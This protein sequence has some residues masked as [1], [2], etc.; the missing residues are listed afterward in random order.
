VNILFLAYAGFDTNS[1]LHIHG[2]ANTLS[3]HGHACAVATP[4]PSSLPDFH[5]PPL[6]Q[7]LT[8]ADLAGPGPAFPNGHPP[9]IVHAWTPRPL[10]LHAARTCLRTHPGARLFVH[11]EDDE[12]LV[13][14]RST[15]LPSALFHH[16]PDTLLRWIVPR[17]FSLPAEARRFLASASGLTL[18][19]RDLAATCPPGVPT[20]EILP[21]L[22]WEEFDPS[23]PIAPVRDEFSIPVG[24]LLLVYNGGLHRS[25][26]Q[27]QRELYR[28]VRIL[29]QTGQP[30]TLIRTGFRS[31]NSARRLGVDAGPHIIELGAVNRARMLG[32]LRAADILVQPGAPDLFNQRRLP[33]KLPEFLA[34]GKPVVLPGANL[35][36]LL[37]HG[38]DAWILRTGRAE[39]IADALRTLAA[40]PALRQDLG[41]A[42]AAFARTH[43]SWDRAADRLESFYTNPSHPQ[44]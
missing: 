40:N 21:G 44:A 5:H 28:A 16:L 14:A 12:T 43:F 13:S 41:R 33:S 7:R 27:E 22:D 23:Q 26:Y 8:H 20:V 37:R 34:L 42:A 11:L 29:N 4:T 1:A 25:L 31:E 3:Q 9:D 10:V 30:C 2:L 32:L 24:T 39:E 18:I 38:A 36:R 35:G 19:W 6:Y 17:H 15:R